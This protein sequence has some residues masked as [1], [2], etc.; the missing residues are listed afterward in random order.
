MK[1]IRLVAMALLLVML[2]FSFTAC[3]DKIIADTNGDDDFSLA[4][5]DDAQIKTS[6][7]YFGLAFATGNAEGYK[8][9]VIGKLSGVWQ[10]VQLQV[11]GS[12]RRVRIR[13]NLVVESGNCRLVLVRGNQQIVNDFDI[14][15]EDYFDLWLTSMSAEY[16]YIKLAGESAKISQFEF[17]YTLV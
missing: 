12:G 9:I 15:G 3:S 10:V 11:Q 5:I 4:V 1:R 6:D 8:G 14:H 13:T 17:S 2:A 16:Y 7:E